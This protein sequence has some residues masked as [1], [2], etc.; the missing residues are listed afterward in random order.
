M[1]L[2]EAITRIAKLKGISEDKI[3]MIEY[4]DGSRRKFNYRINGGKLNF[5]L[6]SK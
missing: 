1:T 2:I 4:E 6:L 3:T 5:I